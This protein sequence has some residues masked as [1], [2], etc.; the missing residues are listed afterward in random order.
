M[1]TDVF[2][3]VRVLKRLS[4]ATGYLELGMT[5]HVLECL[6][7]LTPLG[8]FE[9]DVELLRGEALRRQHR[10][11]DAALALKAAAQSSSRSP[12]VEDSSAWLALSLC[13]Q[14]GGQVA[15]ALQ[16]LARAR[17]A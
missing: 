10:Y 9:A 3:F 1:T 15:Q 2:H 13:L 6:D 11:Q 5:Q 7:G 4:E 8:P 16:V 14:Q 17:G 12:N